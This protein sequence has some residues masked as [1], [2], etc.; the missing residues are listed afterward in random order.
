MTILAQSEMA[1]APFWIFLFLGESPSGWS[2]LGGAIILTAVIGK[3]VLD[4]RPQ[5]TA[6]HDEVLEPT[7]D[8]APPPF[9]RTQ[10]S[11]SGLREC[12]DAVGSSAG[13]WL[14]V[15]RAHKN[16]RDPGRRRRW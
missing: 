5:T 2:L 16:T 8:S 13:P 15:T 14:P 10:S 12:C 6:R 3:A 9:D 7:P 11:L 1:F 4:A